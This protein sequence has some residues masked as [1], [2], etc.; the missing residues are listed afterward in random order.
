VGASSRPAGWARR[1]ALSAPEAGSSSEALRRGTRA[2]G[3]RDRLASPHA[4]EVPGPPACLLGHVRPGPAARGVRSPPPACPPC[5]AEPR[6]RC[7]CCCSLRRACITLGSSSCGPVSRSARVRT[8][9]RLS[10]LGMT[11]RKR[12]S[13]FWV[14]CV[15]DLGRYPMSRRDRSYFCR[16]ERFRGLCRW[17]TR[18]AVA[19]GPGGA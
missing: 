17:P 10:E 18:R 19:S 3:P 7:S 15:D 14:L 8:M 16:Q 12:S 5:A 9:G 11:C 6:R 4:A 1:P 13:R 2:R